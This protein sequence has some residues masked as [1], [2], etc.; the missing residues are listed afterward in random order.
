MK[1]STLDFAR[2][3]TLPDLLAYHAEVRPG[4]VALEFEERA[5]T[6]AEFHRRTNLLAASLTQLEP[7]RG[8]RI[9]Y[10][11]RNS[12]RY[13]ELLFAAAKAGLVLVPLNCRL[14]PDEWDF[15]VRDAQVAHLFVDDSFD[16]QGRALRDRLS[17]DPVQS[18]VNGANWTRLLAPSGT[19]ESVPPVGANDV[20]LQIYTSGTTGTPKGAM[21]THANVLALREPGLRAGLEWF[22]RAGDSSLVVMP[23]AHIAGTAYGLFGLHSGGRLVIGREFDAGV[24]WALLA[25]SR[26]SHML[27]APTALRMLLEHPDAAG[28]PVPHL[29]YITYGGS[30]IAPALLEQAIA[31]LRCGFTQMYGM[32]EASGGVVALTPNDHLEARPD[33]LASAGRAMLGVELGI[34]DRAGKRLPAGQTGEIVVRSRAVMAGYWQ[35]PEATAETI[36]ASGW[37]RTGDIG[38]LDDDGYLT[39]VDRAKDTIVSGAENVYPLEV[40][41]VLSCHP[42]VQEVAVI[43]IPSVRWGEEV[44]AVVVPRPGVAID[45]A[46]LIDWARQR[47]AAYKVPKS[48]DVAAALPRNPNGKVLRRVLREPYWR[49]QARKVG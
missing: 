30:P 10:L 47:I 16:I 24:V 37:L 20:V 29:R 49:E 33:R 6:Y 36:D 22:P 17:L 23:V 38:V 46:R 44:K 7:Q 31:R 28:T 45:T 39:V 9:G 3:Q 13:F 35:R 18:L 14:T 26:V 48:I 8:R 2:M 41:N 42:D 5:T 34:I 40:E 12:D 43:G 1:S 32:T 21:L 19:I 15:I 4:D 25:R 27:L 11:G